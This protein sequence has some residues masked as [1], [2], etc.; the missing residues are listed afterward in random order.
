VFFWNCWLR[1]RYRLVAYLAAACGLVLLGT[2]PVT[3]KSVHGHQVYWHPRTVG[4]AIGAWD[5]G[6]NRTLVVL[7]LVMLFFAADLG[8]RGLGESAARKECDFLLTRPRTRRNFVWSAWLAALTQ[9]C[10]LELA[11]ITIAIVTLFAQTSGIYSGHLWPLSLEIFVVSVLVFSGAYA[12]TLATGS[13]QSGFELAFSL[14]IIYTL[15]LALFPPYFTFYD[16][17]WV[18]RESSYLDVVPW[19]LG[20]QP[21]HYGVLLMMAAATAALTFLAQFGFEKKDL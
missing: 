21:V 13:S 10:V 3:L 12:L 18:L 6:V 17:E 9:L 2:L 5:L 11:P 4:D 14:L 16:L 7:V 20:N 1:N 19:H 15:G 8:S